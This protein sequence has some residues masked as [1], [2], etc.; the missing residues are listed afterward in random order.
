MINRTALRQW[1]LL[2]GIIIALLA[3]CLGAAWFSA[4]PT[5][6][7]PP[8]PKAPTVALT[9]E[10]LAQTHFVSAYGAELAQLKDTV[11]RLENELNQQKKIKNTDTKENP[12]A[13]DT[14]L[15]TELV[16]DEPNADPFNDPVLQA[17]KRA[18]GE[19]A[20][21]KHLKITR[22][23][24][25]SKP[26]AAALHEAPIA[27]NRTARE[28]ALDLIPSGTFAKAV[29]L[30]GVDAPTGGQA[31]GNPM[32][33]LLELTDTAVLPNRFRSDIARCFITAN[34]TGDLSSERVLIRLD[35]LSCL[36]Q[37]GGAVDV[38]ITGYVAGEDGKTGVRSRVVTR[39]G[40]AIANALLVGSLS[41]LGKAVGL[42][43]QESET[44]FAGT[45]STRVTNPWRSGLGE[46][47][48]DAMGR[49]ADYYM[50]LADKIFPVLELDAGRHVDVV[51]T[52][53]ASLARR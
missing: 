8:A 2:S 49:I 33:V 34:A 7:Q 24:T 41:G 15:P 38:K 42:A 18:P 37:S 3:L 5:S 47:M 11:K 23:S 39:S 35:R 48:Q 51:I 16:S 21:I 28:K 50:K 36:D 44:N 6:A 19:V 10:N 32:P 40:A 13:S 29:L 43:A 31:Q 9:P 26:A 1:L 14:A 46:G 4:A 22:I 45:V 27:R 12:S 52:Q 30:N 25:A 20:S 53:A 17:G